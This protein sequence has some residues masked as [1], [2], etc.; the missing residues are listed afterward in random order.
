MRVQQAVKYLRGGKCGIVNAP[1]VTVIDMWFCAKQIFA[2]ARPAARA[3]CCR[4]WRHAL[5]AG[6]ML[7]AGWVGRMVDRIAVAALLGCQWQ[8]SFAQSDEP[9]CERSLAVT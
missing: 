7:R 6:D 9:D 2:Q 1:G 4:V 3:H 5:S 8:E